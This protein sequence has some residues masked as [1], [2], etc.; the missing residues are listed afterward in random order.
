M[1]R[2][3][4]LFHMV[5]L[6]QERRF[7]TG[8]DLAALLLGARMVQTWADP[9]LARAARTMLDKVEAALPETLAAS[10]QSMEDRL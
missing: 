2:A 9:E 10:M 4:R 3:D 1:R 8:A 6:L 7:L 5:R